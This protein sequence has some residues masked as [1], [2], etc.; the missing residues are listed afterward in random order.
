MIKWSLM[1]QKKKN[2]PISKIISPWIHPRLKPDFI[3][4]IEGEVEDIFYLIYKEKKSNLPLKYESSIR[5]LRRV[6]D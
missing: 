3:F 2:K 5:T 1:L 6:H 4:K